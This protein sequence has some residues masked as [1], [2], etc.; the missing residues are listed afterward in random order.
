MSAWLQRM[1]SWYHR[2]SEPWYGW[3]FCDLFD[4]REAGIPLELVISDRF[5]RLTYSLAY[6]FRGIS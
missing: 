1:D 5:R 2:H 3:V 6:L 4:W